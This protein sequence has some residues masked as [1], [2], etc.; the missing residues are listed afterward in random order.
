[1]D[2]HAIGLQVG[3]KRARSEQEAKSDMSRRVLMV[4]GPSQVGKSSTIR[5]LV[6]NHAYDFVTNYTTRPPRRDEID[7]LDYHFITEERFQLM[8]RERAFIDW[9]YFLSSYGGIGR[10][11]FYKTSDRPRVMHVL[12]RMA[13]RMEQQSRVAMA[14]FL[15]PEDLSVV[16]ARVKALFPDPAVAAAR[17]AHV[18]EEMLHAGMFRRVVTVGPNM[19]VDEV[20][21]RLKTAA[22]E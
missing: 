21:R 1:M 4:V 14:V 16:Y 12:A 6:E 22:M 15:A 8:V 11:S 3:H 5:A 19:S 2:D 13:L 18:E 7:G 20:A 10:R 17:Y 9:D